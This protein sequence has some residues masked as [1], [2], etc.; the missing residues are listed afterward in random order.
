MAEAVTLW[1]ELTT[2]SSP[3]LVEATLQRLSTQEQTRAQRFAFPHDKRDYVLAHA[4]LRRLLASILGSAADVEVAA[5]SN[6]RPFVPAYPSA[7]ISLSHATG[8]VACAGTRDAAIGVDVEPLAR[9]R[10]IEDVATACLSD[11][12]RDDLPTS[13][14]ERAHA[15]VDLWT[16]KEA[17]AKALGL[18]L[19]MPLTQLTF[20]LDGSSIQCRDGSPVASEPWCFAVYAPTPDYR[21]ALAVRHEPGAAPAVTARCLTPG[22][23]RLLQPVRTSAAAQKNISLSPTR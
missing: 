21:V 10:N 23:D 11:S 22:D 13:A 7:G 4:L 5:D 8:C 9:W 6:G 18:G 2:S 14:D 19:A 15:L 12:E 3:A 1:C 16:L 17:T 20:R